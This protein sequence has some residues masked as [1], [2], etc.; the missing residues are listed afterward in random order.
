MRPFQQWLTALGVIAVSPGLLMAGPFSG[1]KTAKPVAYESAPRNASRPNGNQEMA[2]K[3][4][5]ALRKANLSGYNIEIQFQGG[6][7]QLNGAVASPQQKS[8][9]T[10]AVQSVA[11]VNRVDN[12]LEVRASAQ[13]KTSPVQQ[14]SGR[15]AQRPQVRPAAMQPEDIE[16][17]VVAPQPPVNI[18]PA[19][20]IPGPG[21]ALPPG[22][23][24]P[25]PYGYAP[26]GTA[27]VM[28]DSPNFPNYAWPSYASYPN[29]A[30]VNYPTQYSASAW[31][32]IG[33]FYPYP[34]VPLGWRK[35]QLEWDDGFW[36]LNFRP[37][38]D[39]WWWFMD[40]RNW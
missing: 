14:A 8:A 39:R 11:G 31:P 27:P 7:A 17:E 35:A 28:Y 24:P 6:T 21:Q 13:R 2:E 29:S 36:Q 20:P 19:G 30:Q 12:K 16:G 33:P 15:V 10:K 3:V 37:R 34:Q 40:Y 5:A 9:A 26:N 18:P 32:Y 4:A 25:A 23:Q 38:T 22:M 1:P